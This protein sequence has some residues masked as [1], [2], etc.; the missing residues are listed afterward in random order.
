M[1]SNFVL[2]ING[3]VDASQIQK[4]LSKMTPTITVQTV[5]KGGGTKAVTTYSDAVNNTVKVTKEFNSQNQLVAEGIS[6]VSVN[7]E[8]ATTKIGQL[9]KDFLTTTT[10]VL[11]FGASTAVIGLFTAACGEAVTAMSNFDDA[12][13]DFKKV[14][15]LSG[16]SLTA[17]VDELD[18]LGKKVYRSSTEM[19]Q[20]A[21]VFKQAGYS[22]EDA[23]VLSQIASLYQNVADKEI[24]ASEAGDY[25]VATMKA[26][27]MS[28][29]DAESIIDKTNAVSNDFATTSTDISS[30]LTKTASSFATYGNTLDQT[31]GMTTAAMEQMPNQSGKVARGLSSI[32][33]QIVKMANDTGK[34]TFKVQGATQSLDL[35]DKQGNMLNTFQ[36][37][38]EIKDSWDKMTTAEQS[39]LAL[40]LGMKT[41]IGVFTAEMNN[42]DTAIAAAGDSMNSLGSAEEENTKRADSWKVALQNINREFTSLVTGSQLKSILTLFVNLGTGILKVI[43]D[44]GLLQ[45]ALIALGGVLTSKIISGV[46]TLGTKL[47]GMAANFDAAYISTGNFGTALKVMVGESAS[48][49]MTMSALNIAIA[50]VTAAISAVV[51]AYNLYKS[52]QQ[53][54]INNAKEA[55]S[56]YQQQATEIKDTIDTIE[57]E[58]TTR[59][60]LIAMMSK[61]DSSYNTEKANLEDINSLRDDAIKKL[62]EEAKAKAAD[63]QRTTGEQYQ[64][65]K[66]YLNS[67]VV[68]HLPSQSDS[69]ELDVKRYDNKAEALKAL[70]GQLDAYN[71]KLQENGELTPQEQ[72]NMG[73]LTDDYN[74]LNDKVTEA[75]SIVDSYD[76][77]VKVTSESYEEWKE[78]TLGV[79]DAQKEATNE[80]DAYVKGLQDATGAMA[81]YSGALNDVYGYLDDYNQAIKDTK[82]GLSSAKNPMDEL[83]TAVQESAEG[84]ST[85]VGQISSYSS[86]I[87]TLAQAMTEYNSTGNL[88]I[89]TLTSLLS[90]GDEYIS[91]LDI[92]DG[93][94]T[95]NTKAAKDL[96]VQKIDEAEAHA[97]ASAQVEIENIKNGALNKTFENSSTS[98]KIAVQSAQSAAQAALTSGEDAAKASTAW[99]NYWNTVGAGKTDIQGLSAD[100]QKAIEDEEK[101][102]EKQIEL[103]EK[104]KANA[105]K[106]YTAAVS[107]GIKAATADSSKASSKAAS[108]AKKAAEEAEK[109]Y[110]ESIEQKQK[111]IENQYKTG[112]I[113]EKEYLKEL[114]ALN[115]SYYGKLSG[116]GTKYLDEYEKNQQSIYDGIKDLAKAS[117]EATEKSMQKQIDAVDKEEDAALDAI[118]K[119]IDAVK[120]AEDAA[121]KAIENQIDSLK[122]EKEDA[123]N[124]IQDQIDALKKQKDAEDKYWDDRIDKLKAANTE[125]SNQNQL[126]EYQ[127]ALAQAQQSKVMI[128]GSSGKFEYQ[129]DQSSVSS[130]EKTLNDY[131]DQLD[132][133]KQL[134]EL[135]DYKEAADENYEAQIE[136]LEDLKDAKEDWYD[137]QIED[138]ENYK[139]SVQEQYDAQIEQL[140]D[141][142]DQVQE[143]YDAQK[144]ILQDQL[145][146]YKD[147]EDEL[148]AKQVEAITAESAN[149]QTR[150]N[151]LQSFVNSYNAMLASLGEAGASVSSSYKAST[152]TSTSS[153]SKKSTKKHA[154]GVASIASDETALV[155]DSPNQE[156]VVGSKINGSIMNLPKGSGV[157]NAQSTKTLA[158]LIN[159]LGSTLGVGNYNTVNTA[160]TRSTS[161]TISNLNVSSENGEELVNYLQNFGMQMTQDAYA[162]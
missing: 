162:Y 65:S 160:N 21:T 69:G 146:N 157:V 49:T 99:A 43:N 90:L 115:E 148:I 94:I 70:S 118:D 96:A 56:T 109:A 131:Q 136:A 117:V 153:S 63:V 44:A 100:Q 45:V 50:G 159:T 113:S 93:K 77:S 51:I 150:L 16:D 158:G 85:A 106:D 161:I 55:F 149:W 120:D 127:Q 91:L 135:E 68:T 145:D 11:Q 35:F 17:Y 122:D 12:L 74:A 154:S 141:Y 54:S 28:A 62:Y 60:Q 15:D 48:A 156:L 53:E 98:S 125:L 129:Q 33:A 132:Y 2:K 5:M 26:F 4:D 111:F 19:L 25:I 130:A 6:R 102:T 81:D 40:T 79:T 59:A 103:L 32:G 86:G 78:E 107:S 57:S 3:K 134:Q 71:K 7:A 139:D 123:L 101:S 152:A 52:A 18:Q 110:K 29:Q 82:A 144:Q 23:A 133:E 76:A 46:T 30:A 121:L 72:I 42:F 10:K 83:N 95:I 34:L 8:K 87:S 88:S 22:D 119:Q 58:T 64:K 104:A 89:S 124:A 116:K 151:N 80:T 66:N 114:Y 38:S 128:L 61:M 108:D 126:M 20:G 97:L 27:N 39:S 31:I 142:K 143:Q 9:G 75:Q 14:S 155:G 13:T 67:S 1:A 92:Q 37:L 41:Q 112:K 147:H 47:V 73:L 105:G 24:T 138:L 84:Y 36:V 137:E 140:N